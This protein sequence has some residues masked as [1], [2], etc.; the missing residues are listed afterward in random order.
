MKYLGNRDLLKLRKTG[1]LCS[2]KCPANVVLKSYNW[3]KQ[4]RSEGHCIVCG[5]HSKIEKDVFDILL[6]GAQPLILVLGRSL[7]K[8]KAPEINQA[9][10][11]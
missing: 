11:D 1:F 8:R 7:Y 5:N 3:A 4:Q 6:K 2:R 10:N 9:L